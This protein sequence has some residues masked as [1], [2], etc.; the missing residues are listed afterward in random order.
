MTFDEMIKNL[1]IHV[2]DDLKQVEAISSL[3]F[4][5]EVTGRVHDG[6]LKIKYS[7]GSAYSNGGEVKGGALDPVLTEYK[8]RFGWDQRHQP[9]C[10]SFDGGTNEV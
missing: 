3:N 1:A 6:D 4:S 7:I 2:R 8:R 5:I 9:L 10:I